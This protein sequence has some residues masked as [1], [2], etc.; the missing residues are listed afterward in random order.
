MRRILIGVAVALVLG[1]ALALI[2]LR[3]VNTGI[4]PPAVERVEGAAADTFGV[5][6]SIGSARLRPFRGIHLQD[7]DV[8]TADDALRA[9]SETVD[10]DVDL[11]GLLRLRRAT[12]TPAPIDAGAIWTTAETLAERQLIPDA[13]TARDIGIVVA[14]TARSE[15]YRLRF[16][17]LGMLHE[18]GGGVIRFR[19]VGSSQ[20]SLSGGSPP[21][22]AISAGLVA[23][24]RERTMDITIEL[25]RLELPRIT[26]PS[27]ALTSGSTSA[28]LAARISPARPLRLSGSVELHDLALEAP[29]VAPDTIRPLDMSYT[30]TAEYAPHVA[31]AEIPTSV[32]ASVRRR[33]PRGE[34][35]ISDGDASINGVGFGLNARLRG[36]HAGG[37]HPASGA[38][39]FLPRIIQLQVD[40]PPTSTSRIHDAVPRALQGPLDT[41]K[42]EGSFSW[43]LDLEVP[44]Y[45]PGGLQWNAETR[46]RDFAVV[47]IDESV[48]P[49]GLNGTF[50][51]TIRDPEFDYARRVR[52]PPAESA[53]KLPDPAVTYVRLDDMSPWVARAVLTAEDGDF[54]YHNGVN[55]RTMAQAAV[56]N[57]DEGGVVLG[58]STISM[59][60]VKML[61]LD[62]DR[63][64]SRKLQEVFLVYLMEHEVPVSKD[65]ILEIYLNIAEFGPGVYGI[66]DAARYY[67]DTS[68]GELT[69]GEATFL[70][71]I[72]PAPK[73]Y[74]WYYERGGITDG[75]FIRMKSYYDI[76]LERDRMTPEEY[77]DA[78][79]ERPEFA[80]YRER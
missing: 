29:V 40:L 74:H 30:F 20:Q 76:M 25:N 55:F 48:S 4:L 68:A 63:V 62:D 65:R 28:S 8:S 51:H 37:A 9:S 14:A 31:S 34:L 1:M 57:L 19:A 71:S 11:R 72:L 5:D 2:L 24:Y 36:L 42:L 78:V 54:Y 69:A 17:E 44:R 13:I 22:Q 41:M 46:L 21:R 32:P 33:F 43:R 39:A 26:L 56:R 75:W 66:R 7:I 12:R 6:L 59:Q 45:N 77:A 18:E 10:V 16:D 52:I 53:A 23:A 49:F 58:A 35:A 38:P 64:F 47:H 70:A 15:A 73:R 67:F 61:F 79:E 50:I 60:L 27:A 80:P 3:V